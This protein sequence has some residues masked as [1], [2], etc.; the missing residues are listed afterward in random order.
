MIFG[1]PER[2]NLVVNQTEANSDE[3]KI[4]ALLRQMQVQEKVQIMSHT[5][6]GKPSEPEAEDSCRPIKLVLKNS[7]MAYIITANSK[8]L[9]PLNQKIFCK[10]DK[11]AKERE[12]FQRLLKKKNECL[13]THPSGEEGV[14]R[15]VLKKGVLTVDGAVVDRYNTPQTIF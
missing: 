10:P 9:K 3:S 14:E 7:S 11:T 13:L 6:I 15:V 2:E 5:R 1:V 8:L 12:E 4:D